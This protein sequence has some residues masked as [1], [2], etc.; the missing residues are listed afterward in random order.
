M[1]RLYVLITIVIAM[2]VIIVGI[3]MRHD[4]V[5]AAIAA[6]PKVVQPPPKQPVYLRVRCPKGGGDGV[7]NITEDLTL[8]HLNP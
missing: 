7:Y 2:C 3:K 5:I 8:R 6:Q 4:Q 1:T